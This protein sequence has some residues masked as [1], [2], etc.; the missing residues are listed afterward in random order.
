MSDSDPDKLADQLEHEAAE[1]QKQSEKLHGD[2]A[3]VREDWERKRHDPDMPGALEP[4]DPSDD[5]Q[6]EHSPA[7]QAPPEEEG[8]AAAETPP[9]GAVGP[10]K[11]QLE[12]G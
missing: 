8:P 10:P 1:L 12:E 6:G 11:E 3:E 5:A 7:P 9:E 2:V 4:M